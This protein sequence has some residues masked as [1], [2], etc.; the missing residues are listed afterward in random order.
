MGRAKEGGKE[1]GKEEGREG[2]GEEAAVVVLSFSLFWKRWI[3]DPICFR[4]PFRQRRHQHLSCP[5][6]EQRA[7]GQVGREGGREGGRE[8][9]G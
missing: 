4:L 5:C 1:G 9:G 6:Q 3:C 7:W 8:R 2:G